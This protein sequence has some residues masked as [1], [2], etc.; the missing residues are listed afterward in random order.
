MMS[1]TARAY[2]DAMYAQN[3]DPWGFETSSYEKRKYEATIAALP[4]VRYA[5]ALEPGCSIG[6]LTEMLAPRCEHL[7]A[8]DIVPDALRQAAERVKAFPH[9]RVERRSI[10]EEWPDEE[11]DLIVL[12]EIAYYFEEASL[13]DITRQVVR[14]TVG[15]AHVL[16]VHWC[17]ETDYP[18]SGLRTHDL[19]DETDCLD[20]IDHLRGDEYVLDVWERSA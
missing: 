16:G 4:R 19:I 17:G 8:T 1:S 11:F 15:G 9:V 13:R 3:S 12:S 7:L 5:N 20:R 14:S 2:F 10:S 6:V 18:L